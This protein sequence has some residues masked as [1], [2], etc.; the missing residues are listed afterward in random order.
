MVSGRN[1]FAD[2][3]SAD[4]GE[5]FETL[6]EAAGV[7]VE[8]IV[9]AGQTTPEGEWWDQDRR[10]WVCL[11]AGRATIRFAD[12]EVSELCPG[13]WLDIPAHRRHRVEWSDPDQVN[14]W[15]AVHF[16]G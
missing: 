7:R 2:L 3:P 10:E 16:E 4:A 13:D 14:V 5:V 1:L 6:V 9:T 15:L 8:R 11:L 12:G